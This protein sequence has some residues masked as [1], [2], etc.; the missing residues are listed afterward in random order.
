MKNP[1]AIGQLVQY[2][3]G[4]GIIF[5]GAIALISLAVAGVQLII[6]QANPEGVSQAKD[7]IR[8]SL[9]GVVLLM[10]SFII[11]KSINPVLLKTEVTPLTTGPGVFYVSADNKVETTC[12]PSESDTSSL[13]TFAGGNIVYR[14]ATPTEPNL[15]IWVYDKPNFDP[16]ST[17]KFTYEK[18]CGEN[19][20]IPASGSFKIGFK[21]PGVYFYIDGNCINDGYRSSVVLTSGQLPEEF[22]NIKGSVEFV[23]DVTYKNYYGVILHERINESGGGNC[24]Y[25]MFSSILATDCKEITLNSASATVFT[26]NDQPIKS[27]DGI[28]FYSGAYGWDTKGSRAGIYELKNIFITGP[29]K[30]DP[31]TMIF[32][33]IGSGV[34]LNE[35][36][37]KPNFKKSPGS[38]RIKGNYLVALYSSLSSGYCQ[39][40]KTNAVDLK[41]TEYVGPG[42]ISIEAVHVI[43]TK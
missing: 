8:G 40:F 34:D 3:F 7:R 42:N 15:L 14:C 9:L 29:K 26:Q 10:V 19:F 23:N 35:Q 6:G 38:I 27:G 41:G 31:A 39:V 28:D 4:I 21:T 20:P 11:L 2:F 37:A 30:Y 25:P 18:K 5:S 1:D 32:N 22:K 36:I 43:P 16:S 12:P 13:T 33:Y 17:N 24:Q